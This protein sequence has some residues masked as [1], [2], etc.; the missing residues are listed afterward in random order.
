M[1]N[2][3]GCQ[4]FIQVSDFFSFFIG[5]G[6]VG[7]GPGLRGQGQRSEEVRDRPLPEVDAKKP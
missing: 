4:V 3:R 5:L 6:F 2:I 7:E 1:K